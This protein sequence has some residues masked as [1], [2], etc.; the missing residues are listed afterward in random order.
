MIFLKGVP[1]PTQCHVSPQE[2]AAGPYSTIIPPNKALSIGGGIEWCGPLSFSCKYEV[3][4]Y[5]HINILY[6]IFIHI[7]IF[8]GILKIYRFYVQWFFLSFF[9]GLL[10]CFA[11]VFLGLGNTSQKWMPNLHYLKPVFP[12]NETDRHV[13]MHWGIQHTLW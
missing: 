3:W 11:G 4:R 1:L 2:M 12:S 5:I 9:W 13:E 7:C 6:N 8:L 10:V